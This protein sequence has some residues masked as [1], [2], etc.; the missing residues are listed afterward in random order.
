MIICIPTPFLPRHQIPRND[1][2]SQ[3][4]G[5]KGEGFADDQEKRVYESEK[6][7]NQL[8]MGF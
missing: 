2:S 7:T 5:K 8:I 3:G 4:T 1:V 6:E